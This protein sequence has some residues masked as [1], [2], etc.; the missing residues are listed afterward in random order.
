MA[1]IT[2]MPWQALRCV[3]VTLTLT[4]IANSAMM[5]RH[6]LGNLSTKYA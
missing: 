3:A 1:Y 4:N 2:S 5:V 6:S